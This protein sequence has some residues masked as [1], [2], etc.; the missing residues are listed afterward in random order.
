MRVCVK[1]AD[2]R[3]RPP[4]RDMHAQAPQTLLPARSTFAMRSGVSATAELKS[5]S[6]ACVVLLGQWRS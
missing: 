4:S 6:L 3:R 2:R 1:V 5:S